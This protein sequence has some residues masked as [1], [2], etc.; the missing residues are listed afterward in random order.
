MENNDNIKAIYLNS[1]NI[2]ALIELLG[3]KGLIDPGEF[4]K[5]KDEHYQRL[6]NE[7]E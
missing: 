1:A 2:M 4:E 5:L 7:N 3:E 6:T